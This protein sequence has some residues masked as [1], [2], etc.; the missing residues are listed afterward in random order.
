MISKKYMPNAIENSQTH[1]E[2]IEIGSQK[3]EW[4]DPAMVEVMRVNDARDAGSFPPC[5]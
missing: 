5:V 1:A 3:R 2:T 4:L